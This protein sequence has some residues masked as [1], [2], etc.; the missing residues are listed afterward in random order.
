MTGPLMLAALAAFTV[1]V[2]LYGWW[3]D[4]TVRRRR[5]LRKMTEAMQRI[6]I[7]IGEQLIPAFQAMVPAVAE[8]A[9]SI[10]AL[11]AALYAGMVAEHNAAA[12]RG[13]HADP[14]VYQ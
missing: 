14:E 4:P 6:Q 1:S 2:C 13:E 10:E 11:G 3:N 7:T 9:R 8:C 12:L 5:E